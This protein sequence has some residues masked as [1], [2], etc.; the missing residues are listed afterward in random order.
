LVDPVLALYDL[1]GAQV[2][3]LNQIR[4]K[5]AGDAA[6][7]RS[8][9]T[10]AGMDSLAIS[11][12]STPPW[13]SRA[14]EICEHKGIGH[15]DSICDGIAEAASQAPCHTYLEHY[16]TIQHHNVDKAL[17]VGGEAQPRFGG[18]TS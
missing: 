16:G 2:F 11:I 8:R 6:K 15:P 1:H 3:D 14:V 12:I 4:H 7:P 18:G 13:Y 9:H 5:G 17:P 10:I